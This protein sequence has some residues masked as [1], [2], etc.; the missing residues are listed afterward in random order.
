[1]TVAFKEAENGSTREVPLSVQKSLLVAPD[2][3]ID[4]IKTGLTRFWRTLPSQMALAY[5]NA[6][7]PSAVKT[8]AQR[9]AWLSLVQAEIFAAQKN[10]KNRLLSA[11]L[12][13]HKN[14][15]GRGA[16]PDDGDP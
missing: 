2:S 9:L 11:W 6:H 10:G 7:A 4:R 14:T 5:P 15:L 13:A 16:C 12:L 1:M 8:Q 3:K